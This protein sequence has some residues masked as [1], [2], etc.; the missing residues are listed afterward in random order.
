M[1]TIRSQVLIPDRKAADRYHVCGRTL[2]RWD[3]TPGLGFP[4]PIYLKGRRY[5][6]V[7]ALDDWDNQN[8]RRAAARAGAKGPP[9]GI[10]RHVVGNEGGTRRKRNPQNGQGAERRR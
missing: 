4:P 8:S 2:L 5:R 7:A 3:N 9:A 10:G 6:S 1:N